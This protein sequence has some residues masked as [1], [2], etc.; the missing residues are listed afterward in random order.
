MPNVMCRPL[1]RLFRSRT[2]PSLA[3]STRKEAKSLERCY[4]HQ[5]STGVPYKGRK[6]L[7]ARLAERDF[8]QASAGDTRGIVR[9]LQELSFV[10]AQLPLS[11]L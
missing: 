7:E 6:H 5:T 3:L 2:Q 8:G 11:M 10:A 1:A 9:P 4:K